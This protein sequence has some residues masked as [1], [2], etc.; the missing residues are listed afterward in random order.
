MS[1]KL[2]H[3]YE[4]LFVKATSD[5]HMASLAI[6]AHDKDIDE[7]TIIFH[8]QQAA[9]KLLKAVLS[10]QGVHF[11][12]V[13]DL[14]VLIE[15]CDKNEIKLPGY[16]QRFAE[17]NPFAVIGRYDFFTKAEINLNEWEEMLRQF[18]GFIG[19]KINL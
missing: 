18:R 2:L 13:H 17:L 10:F 6:K 1:E 19:N 14:T 3:Q 7:A 15:L 9:E 11:E 4:I 8:F 5:L 16:T 12:K